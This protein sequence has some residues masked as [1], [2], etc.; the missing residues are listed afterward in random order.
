MLLRSIGIALTLVLSGCIASPV[1]QSDS[2]KTKC[3]DPAATTEELAI[4]QFTTPKQQENAT[5]VLRTRPTPQTFGLTQWQREALAR[6][7]AQKVDFRNI[8]VAPVSI[9]RSRDALENI[10]G[11]VGTHFTNVPPPQVISDPELDGQWWLD[12]INAPTAWDTATGTGVVVADCDAGFYVEE[13]DLAANLLLDR[14]QDFANTDEPDDVSDGPFVEHGTAVAAILSGVKDEAGTNGIAFDSKLIPLQNSNYDDTDVLDKEEATAKCIL[15]ALA[16]DDVDIILLENQTNGSSE[17]Y[18]GTREAVT[19][20]LE[21][22]VTIVSAAGNSGNELVVEQQHDTGSIIVGALA[23]DGAPI[24]YSNWG[25]RVSIAGY[26]EQLR[27]LLGPDGKLGTFGGTSGAAPQVAAAVAL[28]LEA[29]PNLTPAAIKD[30][31]IAT[32]LTSDEITPVGGRLDVA[33]AV[34]EATLRPTRPLDDA[35][36]QY[37]ASLRNILRQRD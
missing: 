37:R 5:K 21:M 17:T 32:R 36:R 18:L 1:E 13:S 2:C 35:T 22:G 6:V 4:F 7:T 20:A 3:D 34:R 28:M 27:T 9:S 12:D 29:N 19:L 24:S 31:L 8:S 11:F 16:Y 10:D 15:G 23:R 14:A 33:S 26:G 25:T 30:I